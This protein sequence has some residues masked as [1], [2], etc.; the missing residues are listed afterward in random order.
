MPGPVP[1]YIYIFVYNMYIPVFMNNEYIHDIYNKIVVVGLG[2]VQRAELL[3][4]PVHGPCL[5]RHRRGVQNVRGDHEKRYTK[6]LFIYIYIYSYMYT[7]I[8]TYL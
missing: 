6:D 2:L 5:F 7:Y 3:P 1:L 4:G 8:Y